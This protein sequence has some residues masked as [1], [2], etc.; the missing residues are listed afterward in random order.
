M[1]EKFLKEKPIFVKCINDD[2]LKVGMRVRYTHTDD[3]S[4]YFNI[5]DVGV[6]TDLGLYFITI[7][8]DTYGNRNI[9]LNKYGNEQ[10]EIELI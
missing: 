9:F 3:K 6:I 2:V 7:K 4:E 1:N 8:L 5:D 10:D